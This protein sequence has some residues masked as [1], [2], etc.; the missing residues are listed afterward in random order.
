MD[1][2]ERWLLLDNI[3]S[4]ACAITMTNRLI[5]FEIGAAIN[6]LRV[7]SYVMLVFYIYKQ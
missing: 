1:M 4:I 2:N 3:R 7:V 5:T 6:S